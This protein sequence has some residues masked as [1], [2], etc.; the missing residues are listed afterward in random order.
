[1][2]RVYDDQDQR[3]D[4][5]LSPAD[6]AR[7]DQLNA[8]G[9]DLEANWN[10][11]TVTPPREAGDN[12]SGG[13]NGGR[14]GSD[15]KL[16]GVTLPT[17]RGGGGESAA[18]TG[19]TAG[20][21]HVRFANR[22]LTAMQTDNT[23][24]PPAMR[25]V[26]KIVRR[27]ARYKKV[28]GGG[29]AIGTVIAAIVVLFVLVLPLKIEHIISNLQ[30]RFFA[31]SQQAVDGEI[32][33]IFTDYVEKYVLPSY[34]KC[35]STISK[36]CNV[37][38]TGLGKNPVTQLYKGWSEVR[39]E[40][41]L[42]ERGI[43]L[44][45]NKNSGTWKLKTPA[46][47]NGDDIG[48]NG[49]G[50][51][52]EFNTH[53]EARAALSKAV[54]DETKWYEA[55][56][57]Y[58]IGRLAEEKYGIFRCL[59]F[60]GGRDQLADKIADQKKAAQL[61]IAE[62]VIKPDDKL[63]LAAV[64]CALDSSCQPGQTSTTPCTDGKDCEMNGEP[65][66][67]TEADMTAEEVQLAAQYGLEGDDLAAFEKI[68][69]DIADKGVDQFLIEQ[70]LAVVLGADAAQLAA[71]KISSAI[72]IIGWINLAD[73]IVEG[74]NDAGPKIKK[75]AYIKNAAVAIDLFMM[76]RAYA[77]EIHA[78]ND[79]A[80]EVGAMV[81]AFSPGNNGAK[82]DPE[83]G[84]TAGAEGTPLYENLIDDGAGAPSRTATLLGALL[85]ANAYAAGPTNTTG[86]NLV[87]AQDYR[88]SNAGGLLGTG[89]PQGV[90]KGKLV[91]TE[92][93]LGQGFGPLNAIHS[94]LN[95]PGVHVII[96]IANFWKNTVG[97]VF[98]FFGDILG[99]LISKPVQLFDKAPCPIQNAIV[100]GYCAYAAVAKAASGKIMQG[101]LS[102]IPNAVGTN[103]SGGRNFDVTAAGADALGSEYAHVG[104][105]G[106]ELTPQE[107]SSV[108]A[109]QQQEQRDI[110]SQQPFFARMFSTDTPYSLVSRLAMDVPIGFQSSVR[111]GFASLITNPFGV[112]SHSFAMAFSGKA[113]AVVSS[114]ADPFGVTQF[115]YMPEDI[116][117]H[118]EEDWN[119]NCKDGAEGATTQAWNAAAAAG[120]TDP[121]NGMPTN[122]TVDTCLLT[123]TATGDASAKF[124][125]DLLTADDLVDVNGPVAGAATAVNGGGAYQN[126][127]HTTN[128]LVRSRIDEG[129]D[130][131]SNGP[132]P[133]YAIGPGIVT[134]K[135]DH[136]SFYTTSHGYADWITY[137]LTSGPAAGDFVYVSEACSPIL[138]GIGD[139]VDNNTQLCSV[140]PDSIETGWA[141]DATSQAA[142]AFGA[143]TGNGRTSMRCCR[144]GA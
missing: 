63:T 93:V 127:F 58:K 76:W 62:R 78:G 73:Q 56:F 70:I 95:L 48:S 112:I 13:S 103:M 17:I 81:T 26:E 75:L 25:N 119:A 36:N 24:F 71:G 90:P 115:G 16:A 30:S 2:A 136:S 21:D 8:A 135:T 6:Q 138:V 141:L 44:T 125:S 60:C 3:A 42:A 34:R 35:G 33:N 77:D 9:N 1:V 109:D 123:Q 133:I 59:I 86:G 137:Q 49:Q 69:N 66:S 108:V 139:K 91:C 64:K 72:P 84:G 12:Q 110:F 53:G 111:D 104:L 4:T 124:T 68:L 85:P 128:G 107:A 106:R 20:D 134:Q 79:N 143:Y 32:R 88:C 82:T 117:K 43:E 113:S 122:N 140:L 5:G 23:L 65:I 28:A 39:L 74:A 47:P 94:F 45:Y 37:H 89:A 97:A 46:T 40:N 10:L 87:G 50:L 38:L 15:H 101:L 31:S 29:A 114:D 142:A 22:A 118:P 131:A 126:P 7:E 144:P 51:E 83:L 14:Y 54:E 105:G 18:N 92:E 120:P 55:G 102:L 132:V 57:R 19:E 96:V 98:K 99:W 41:K 52:R 61:F 100:P 11:P 129:A 121:N 27:V 67:A 130:F 80:T 116:P